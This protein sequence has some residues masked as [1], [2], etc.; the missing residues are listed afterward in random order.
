MKKII[1]WFKNLFGIGN[2]K[3]LFVQELPQNL[4]KMTVYV[5]GNIKTHEKYYA[6]FICPCG[7]GDIL[8]LNLIDDVSPVWRIMEDHRKFSIH[9]SIWRK[10]ICKSHFWIKQN[11][12]R[13][14]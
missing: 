3:L 7:C 1:N 13:W 5:E 14:V 4:N 11:K 9:P 6:N 12:V 2:Y 10:G 8:T